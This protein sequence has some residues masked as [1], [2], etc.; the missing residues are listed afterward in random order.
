MTR[1]RGRYVNGVS[2]GVKKV[3]RM[4]HAPGSYAEWLAVPWTAGNLTAVARDVAG[5]AVA[6]DARFTNGA[7]AAL[8]LSIDA[9]SAVT[10]TGSALLL[11]G[12]DAALLRASVVDAA[13]RVMHLAT[14]NVSFRVVSGPGAVQGTHNGDTHS[15]LPNN[16]PWYP[17]YHGLVRAVI[18]VTSSAGRDVAERALL[19]QIDVSGPMAATLSP[20]EAKLAMDTSP[21]LVE[22]STPGLPPVRVSI[23]TSTDPADGVLAVAQAAAGKPVDFFGH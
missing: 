6:T 7:A 20:E 5:K 22:A 13:G 23:P 14:H 1:T 9:P 19:R 12:S 3:T 2:Q 8:T 15:H 17:A 4:V 11:D 18:R 21:I 16:S 10:G